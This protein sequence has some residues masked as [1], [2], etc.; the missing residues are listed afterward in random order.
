MNRD[1][2]SM[3]LDALKL[4]SMSV[5]GIFYTLNFSLKY[6]TDFSNYVTIIK[7]PWIEFK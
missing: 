4:I 6:F 5:N 1:A 7:F 2:E 3:S